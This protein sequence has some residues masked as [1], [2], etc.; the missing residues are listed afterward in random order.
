METTWLYAPCGDKLGRADLAPR[1]Q[2]SQADR[3]TSQTG[4]AVSE[5]LRRRW[6]VQKTQTGG[7]GVQQ[8]SG[9][10]VMVGSQG[11]R[12]RCNAVHLRSVHDPV[13]DVTSDMGRLD[14]RPRE[15]EDFKN[16]DHL[17]CAW[18]IKAK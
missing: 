18:L 9:H 17:C 6:V 15:T 8:R 10:A 2:P 4:A 12:N 7:G 3:Q 11:L 1:A 14:N 13:N 16:I 5:G